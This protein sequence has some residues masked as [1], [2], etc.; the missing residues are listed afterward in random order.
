MKVLLCVPEVSVPVI[1]AT[2]DL[3][4]VSAKA[5]TLKKTMNANVRLQLNFKDEYS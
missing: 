3:T 2:L 5:V 1:L 4:A